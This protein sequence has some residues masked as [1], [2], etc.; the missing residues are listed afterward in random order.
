[1]F[2]LRNGISHYA[3]YRSGPFDSPYAARAVP[4]PA[5]A[6]ARPARVRRGVAQW[7]CGLRGTGSVGG[8]FIC[9]QTQLRAAAL[10][11]ASPSAKPLW[12]R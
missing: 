10:P 1:M 12:P 5:R 9:L 6:R 2:Y 8:C 11:L 4:R 7:Q 3:I